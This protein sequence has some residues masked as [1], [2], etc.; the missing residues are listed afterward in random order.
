MTFTPPPPPPVPPT[1]REIFETFDYPRFHEGAKGWEKTFMDT[2]NKKVQKKQQ[3][4]DPELE[5]LRI[6]HNRYRIKS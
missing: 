3:L 6:L 2:I 5:A 1:I 4:R